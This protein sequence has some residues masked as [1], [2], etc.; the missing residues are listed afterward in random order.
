MSGWRPINR[1]QKASCRTPTEDEIVVRL[2]HKANR[3]FAVALGQAASRE[4]IYEMLEYE[5][6]NHPL[7]P[8]LIERVRQNLCETLFGAA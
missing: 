6:E 3:L 4:S 2:L 1:M 5:I 7:S 8:E